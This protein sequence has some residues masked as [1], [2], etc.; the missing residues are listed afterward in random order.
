MHRRAVLLQ[1]HG[2][3]VVG[4]SVA[5]ATIAAVTL[6]FTA[7]IQLRAMAAGT[8]QLIPGAEARSSKKLLLSDEVIGGKWRHAVR[9]MQRQLGEPIR[10]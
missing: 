5:A 7:D 2:A 1:N 6:E 9:G 10:R 3:L 8:P 4:R